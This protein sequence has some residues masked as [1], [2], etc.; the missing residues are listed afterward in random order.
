MVM[1]RRGWVRPSTLKFNL[2][3]EEEILSGT[4]PFT[5]SKDLVMQSFELVKENVGAAG[6]DRQTIADF[7][8]NLKDNLYKLWNRLSS[9]TYFPPPV[10]AVPIPKKS[11]G[12]RIL[13]VPTV[14]DRIAQMVVKLTFEP[15]VEP[16]FLPDSYGYRPNK[17]ALDAIGVTR[18]RCW[19]YDWIL[20]YDIRGLF[21]NL[22]H[23]LLMKAVKKHTECNWV[24]LYIERWLTAPMQLPDGT[25]LERTRGV[26]QGGVISPIL[27]NLF[28]HYVYD[29]W[30]KRHYPETP[31]CR[32]ADDGLAHCETKEQAE[33]LLEALR[34]RF[35]ECGLELHPDKTKIVYCKD[36]NRKERHPK[37]EF[38]FLGYTF[39]GRLVKKRN[40]DVFFVSFSPAV[41]KGALKSMRAK[42]RQSNWRNRTD[43]SLNEIAQQYNPVLQGWINYYGCYN[44]SSLYPMLG[45]FNRTLVAWAMRKYKKLRGHKTRASQFVKGIAERQPN[46]FAHWKIGMVGSFA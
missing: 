13:G 26:P 25:L 12:E 28:L 15:C 1:E 46:L 36:D 20:E 16:Y 10:K 33:S 40:E 32:Y 11:G 3:Y 43:M 24:I 39:R 4:K 8:L 41:S 45:H 30:M 18:K 14:G 44:R 21:D 35:N 27:S 29:A 22:D 9:G 7:E 19:R 23:L 38:D 42:T 34:Q 31:W 6:I 17:S 2:K 5:I 37:K